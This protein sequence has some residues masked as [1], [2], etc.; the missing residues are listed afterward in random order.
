MNRLIIFPV[1]DSKDKLILPREGYES[2]LL[3]AMTQHRADTDTDMLLAVLAVV[4][5]ANVV[6][7]A[8]GKHFAEIGISEGRFAVLMH[9]SV[10]PEL[11]VSP[12]KLAEHCGVSRTAM[13]GLLDGLEKSGFVKRES[14]P[15]DRRGLMVRLTAKGQE[16]LESV[17]PEE[18]RFLSELMSGLSN[19]ERKR[20]VE[21]AAKVTKLFSN[22]PLP[23]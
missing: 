21:M 20:M 16:F 11:C 23:H 8:L 14:H 15:T 4:R 3:R 5:M 9:L 6:L 1:N 18:Y 2:A 13:T 10:E 7:T 19:S 12:S 22:K 17:V